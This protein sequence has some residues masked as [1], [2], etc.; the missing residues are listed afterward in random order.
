MSIL[1]KELLQ[2]IINNID[3]DHGW[4]VYLL[5]N[6]NNIVGNLKSK[7]KL[8]KIY[9]DTL[10]LGVYESSWMQELFLLSS[11]LITK[12]NSKLDKPRIKHL[13][14]RLATRPKVDKPVNREI[15][16]KKEVCLTAYELSVLSKISD[17]ELSENL[18]KYLV[19]CYENK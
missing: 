18:K 10:V 1:I 6:W 12:I 17:P 11:M 2:N 8:E 14:F 5:A 7:V 4:Q 16:I 13:K 9:E 3:H 19:K 15:K